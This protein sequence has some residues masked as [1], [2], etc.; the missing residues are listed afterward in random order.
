LIAR[1]RAGSPR[2]LDNEGAATN[3]TPTVPKEGMRLPRLSAASDAI[4]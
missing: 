4:K 1:L 2:E 3:R